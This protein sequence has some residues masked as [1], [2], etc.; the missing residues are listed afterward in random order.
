LALTPSAKRALNHAGSPG[1][2]LNNMPWAYRTCVFGLSWHI[3]G[4]YFGL[5][6]H[7]H[8][9]KWGS[10]AKLSCENIMSPFNPW[11]S[12]N[13]VSTVNFLLNTSSMANYQWDSEKTRH[14]SRPGAWTSSKHPTSQNPKDHTTEKGFASVEKNS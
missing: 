9:N 8:N 12:I 10:H 11:E 14:T 1:I 6:C 5:S 13:H 3:I 7:S 2:L 4:P